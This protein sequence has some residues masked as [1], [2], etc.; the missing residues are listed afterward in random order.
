MKRKLAIILCAAI[1][2]TGC[3]KTSE[4]IPH[5]PTNDIPDAYGVLEHL[6]A[7]R[8]PQAAAKHIPIG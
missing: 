6:R 5:E 4:N 2:L 8:I 7:Y 1:L 3:N